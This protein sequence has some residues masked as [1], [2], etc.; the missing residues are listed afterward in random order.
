VKRRQKLE[1]LLK[2]G[3]APVYD[4][5]LQEVRN[6][7]ELVNN[8]NMIQQEQ[9][10]HELITKIK[11]VCFGFDD[12]KQ[13]VFNLMQLLKT[14]FLYM[15]SK[16]DRVEEYKQNFRSI[17]DTVEAFRGLPGIHNGLMDSILETVVGTG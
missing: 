10:L 7:L 9:S 14:L 1:E 4:Q 3:Y 16:K 13:E 17:W 2:N 11:N 8:W 15:Q 12:N 6:K 5:C